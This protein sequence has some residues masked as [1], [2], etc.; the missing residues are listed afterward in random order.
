VGEHDDWILGKNLLNVQGTEPEPLKTGSR[1]LLIGFQR[2]DHFFTHDHDKLPFGTGEQFGLEPRV[3]GTLAVES[4]ED[5][6][7]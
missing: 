7:R 3:C 5:S 4:D 1:G 2:A 6:P